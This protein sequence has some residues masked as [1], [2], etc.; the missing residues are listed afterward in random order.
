MVSF[1]ACSEE[2]SQTQNRNPL[3]YHKPKL[4]MFD[5]AKLKPRPAALFRSSLSSSTEGAPIPFM[6]FRIPTCAAWPCLACGNMSWIKKVVHWYE[7]DIEAISSFFLVTTN[8]RMQRRQQSR[9]TN[10]PHRGDHRGVLSVLVASEVAGYCCFLLL[11]RR[12]PPC[13]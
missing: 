11:A 12:T 1:S 9:A 13:S 4:H 5:K 8:V 6:L 7:N 3:S 2:I 10:V